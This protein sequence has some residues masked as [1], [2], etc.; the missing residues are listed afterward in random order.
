VRV[1]LRL[2]YDISNACALQAVSKTKVLELPCLIN[3]LALNY[4]GID[5]LL[6]LRLK[7]RAVHFLADHAARLA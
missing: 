2:K 6:I 1:S 3:L 7:A 5:S 4:S